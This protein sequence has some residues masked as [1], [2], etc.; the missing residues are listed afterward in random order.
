MTGRVYKPYGAMRRRAEYL[1]EQA[2]KVCREA[3]HDYHDDICR[4][5]GDRKD[6]RK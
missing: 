5:C 2:A 1:R 6:N 4:R 3:G